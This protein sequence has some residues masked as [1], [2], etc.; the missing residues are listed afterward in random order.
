MLGVRDRLHV[1]DLL[2]HARHRGLPHRLHE[3]HGVFRRLRHL[4]LDPPVRVRRIPEERG[5]LGTELEDLGDD[6]VVVVRVAVVTA[7]GEH[8]PDLLAQVAPRRPGEERI[9]ARPRVDHRPLPCLAA[10]CRRRS[11]RFAQRSRKSRKIGFLV[12]EH[13]LRALF[14]EHVLAEPRVQRRE[15]LVQL[16]E[17]ALLRV[18]ELGAR[19]DEFRIVEPQQPLLL[20]IEAQ[21]LAL[22]VHG[23]DAC[24]ETAVLHDPIVEGSELWGHLRLDRLH[25]RV[26]HRRHVDAVDRADAIER[27]PRPF[28]G[29]DRVVEARSGVGG[30]DAIDLRQVLR[31]GRLERRLDVR[32]LE[33]PERRHA[34]PRT[35]PRRQQG[36]HRGAGFFRA[37]GGTV[38]FRGARGTSS[39]GEQQGGDARRRAEMERHGSPG[40]G[41][42][43]F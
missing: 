40:K 8:A 25:L 30:G 21:R 10:R 13:H 26:V 24:E 14:R 23:G 22:F 37:R 35:R 9:D 11:R 32:R 5:A 39:K 38:R 36:V 15:L 16:R 43:P 28:H 6:P 20:G 2:A 34:A 42:R 33:M 3:R 29:R 18:V 27:L 19:A 17:A 1:G 31:H 7:A 41:S 12:D 4:I